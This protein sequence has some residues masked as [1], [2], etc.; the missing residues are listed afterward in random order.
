MKVI[1]LADVKGVG[2]KDEVINAADGYARNFLFPKKLAVEANKENLAKLD[3]AKNA[4]VRKRL[5]EVEDAQALKKELEGKI[6]K[7]SVK[8][9][10]TGRLF[11]SVTNKEIAEELNR[12]EGLVIDRKRIILD[13]PIKT[14]GIKQVDVKLYTDITAKITIEVE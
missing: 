9:G 14:V 2:K 11:G 8:K 3:A 1:L 10:E 12:Q 5:K 4:V 13:E 6:I 7:I